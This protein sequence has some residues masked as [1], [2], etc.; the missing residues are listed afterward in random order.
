MSNTL[1]IKDLERARP[2]DV[3]IARGLI[4]IVDNFPVKG[5][6]VIPKR[7][8]GWYEHLRNQNTKKSDIPKKVGE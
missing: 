2:Q 8:G 6:H 1:K 3:A 4:E 5:G 7:G